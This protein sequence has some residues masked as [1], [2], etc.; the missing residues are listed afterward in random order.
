MVSVHLRVGEAVVFSFCSLRFRLPCILL[1]YFVAFCL[2]IIYVMLI[3]KKK[4]LLNFFNF[5][6]DKYQNSK[7]FPIL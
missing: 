2:L 4:D 5:R 7:D 1:V 3:Y 6:Q